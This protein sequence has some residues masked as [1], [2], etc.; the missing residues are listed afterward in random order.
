MK[1]TNCNF[2]KLDGQFFCLLDLQIIP[3]II[4]DRECEILKKYRKY[5]NTY[6]LSPLT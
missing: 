5:Q 6:N 3:N 1:C 2:I 4:E